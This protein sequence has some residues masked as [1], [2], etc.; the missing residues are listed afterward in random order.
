MR[1]S[2]PP[3]VVIAGASGGIG[4]PRL[5]LV[6]ALAALPL[7]SVWRNRRGGAEPRPLGLPF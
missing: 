5:A 7:L 2:R 1:S 3:T 6:G 4:W